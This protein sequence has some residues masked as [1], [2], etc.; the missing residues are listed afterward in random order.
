MLVF[1]LLFII[2]FL[3]PNGIFF[4]PGLLASLW[5]YLLADFS[6]IYKSEV[7]LVLISFILA[8]PSLMAGLLGGAIDRLIPTSEHE[9]GIFARYLPFIA[10][11]A[12]T[13]EIMT[14]D[15]LSSMLLAIHAFE[16]ADL[17]LLF[18]NATST[19][20]L[21]AASGAFLF[22]LTVFTLELIFSLWLGDKRVALYYAPFRFVI[23]IVISAFLF[24]SL[25]NTL[26]DYQQGVFYAETLQSATVLQITL[27]IM[28]QRVKEAA[29]ILG[30]GAIASLIWIRFN[31]KIK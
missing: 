11:A 14:A 3:I 9:N 10:A 17:F 25:F 19:G 28:M 6:G 26:F 1:F 15:Y 27:E 13:A 21:W 8:L 20:M 24:K 29:I 22:L 7:L 30:I 16:F 12:I 2:V 18:L 5:L 31:L 23:V 4:L